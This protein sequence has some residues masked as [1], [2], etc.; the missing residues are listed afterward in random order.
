MY[1]RLDNGD[2]PIIVTFQDLT[3]MLVAETDGYNEDSNK[4]DDPQWTISL[5]FLTDEEFENLPDPY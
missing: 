4:E 5:V 1:F 3:E 2:Q